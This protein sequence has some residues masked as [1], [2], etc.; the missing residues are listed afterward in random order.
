M[1]GLQ[2]MRLPDFLVKVYHTE[3]DR[4]DVL[5]EIGI[6]R[7]VQCDRELDYK[8]RTRAE[9]VLLIKASTSRI[10]DKNDLVKLWYCSG[11]SFQP[12]TNANYCETAMD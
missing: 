8:Q 11:R 12:N 5:E 2:S 9:T 10:R 6:P 4:K 3:V 1:V 7:L